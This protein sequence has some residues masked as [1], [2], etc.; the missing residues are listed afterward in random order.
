M[1]GVYK[2]TYYIFIITFDTLHSVYEPVSNYTF[3][4]ARASAM[5]LTTLDTPVPLF[6]KKVFNDMLNVRKLI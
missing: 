2:Y 5:S 1:D 3:A 4:V 6:H